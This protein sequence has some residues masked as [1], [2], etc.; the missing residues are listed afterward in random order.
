MIRKSA[1]GKPKRILIVCD[2]AHKPV[3]MFLSQQPKLAKGL[4]RLGHDAR[5]FGYNSVLR[6]LSTFNSKTLTQLFY[7]QK[8]DK[9]L[10]EYVKSYQPNVIYFTFSR[11][12]DV[13]TIEQIRKAAANAVLIGFDDDP[14]P[15]LH[16]EKIEIAKRLDI[17]L[18]TNNGSFLQTYRDAGAPKCAFMPNLC[19]PDTDRRYVVDDKWKTDVLWTGSI[20]HDPRR[21]PAENMR[22]E[23]IR[24]LAEMPNCSVYGCC[25]RPQVGGIDY[26]YAISGAKVGL[27]INADN[28]V[29]LYHSDRLTNYLSCGAFVLAKRVPDSDLLFKEDTHLRYFDTIDEFFELADWYLKHENERK[30]IADSGMN[31]VHEQFN[32]VKIASLILDLVEKGSYSAPWAEIL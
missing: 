30:R 20:R 2:L 4:L 27:N 16:P 12:L 23:I 5:L 25:G 3:K 10:V 21:Y 29:R 1:I 18:A 28:T 9:I 22:F 11:F 32:C 24:R 6:E 13:E 26:F 15:H 7:K 19:D 14:W 31:W 8:A 17:L